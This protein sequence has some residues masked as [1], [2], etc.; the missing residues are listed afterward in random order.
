MR[1]IEVIDHKDFWVQCFDSEKLRIE[2]ILKPISP[3][4][5]HIG[6]TSVLGLAAKPIIDIL[7]EVDDLD[8][9]ESFNIELSQ[10]GYVAKGE[11]GIFERRYYE[12]GGENRSHHIHA[13]LK[14]SQNSTRHLAFRD[15]LKAHKVIAN[16]YAA[17]KKQVVEYCDNNIEIYC[18]GKNEFVQYHEKLALEWYALNK[19]SNPTP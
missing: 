12:K 13:F 3:I 4:I 18:A 15:Y 14:N 16:E 8:A 7:I 1:N 9:L 5:Y 6:S 10:L 17:L 2:V 11:N 19:A